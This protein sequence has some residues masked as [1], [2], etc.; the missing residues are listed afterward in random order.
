MAKEVRM[1]ALGQTTE[2][3]KILEWLRRE[4]DRLELGDPL[5][6]V[7]T[8]KA[9][10]EIESFE[11]GML[12][13]IIAGEGATVQAGDVV[14]YIGEADEPVPD[15]RN[16]GPRQTPKEEHRPAPTM[17]PLVEPRDGPIPETAPTTPTPGK[18][19]ASPAARSLARTHRLDLA[20]IAGT[21]PGGRIEVADVAREVEGSSA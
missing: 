1:P 13:K 15:P 8:D 6:R 7:E 10:L 21:G 12:L 14:A 17:P 19:L 5:I 9:D 11:A 18:Y 3:L 4:G 20:R 2:D 16:D